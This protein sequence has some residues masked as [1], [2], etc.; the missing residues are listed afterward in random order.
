MA[1]NQDDPK[2]DFFD[3]DPRGIIPL[4][5][6][7][8]SR[9]LRK[10]IRKGIFKVTYNA[11]FSSILEGCSRI[12]RNRPTTWINHEIKTVYKQLFDMG[13]CHS[14]EIWYGKSIVGGLYGV[15]IGAAFFGESMFSLKPNA[16]KVALVHLVASLK[17]EG[18]VLLD[19]QF[20]NKHLVQFGAIDITR[21][22]Y[23]SRLR[24]A[25][26]REAKFPAQSP[27]LYY[28]LE[29]EHFKTQTS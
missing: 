15:S 26:N 16:S 7:H 14:I 24:F 18:F 4:E 8:I 29:P 3:P 9:S 6:F 12:S 10:L 11:A 25:V 19:S 2:I 22:D 28:V 27:D 5:N 21:E 17:Q 20:P 1:N 23:K 13:Y